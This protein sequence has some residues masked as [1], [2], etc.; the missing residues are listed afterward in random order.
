MTQ[1]KTFRDLKAGDTVFVVYQQRRRDK[2]EPRTENEIV[3]KVGTKYAYLDAGIV[4][5]KAFDR[6]T[7]K[8]VH[9]G[10]FNARSNGFGFDVYL[11]EL[12]YRTEQAE[13]SEFARLNNR[14]RGRFGQTVDLPPAAVTEIHSVLDEFEIAG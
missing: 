1:P 2:S 12:D 13:E 6:K 11:C 8:S 5:R 7:G 9:A 10:D 3:T 14:L 4:S